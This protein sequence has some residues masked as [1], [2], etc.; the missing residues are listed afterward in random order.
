MDRMCGASI[1]RDKLS[2]SRCWC[3]GL[4]CGRGGAKMTRQIRQHFHISGHATS[5]DDLEA[6]M[7]QADLFDG[8]ARRELW[9]IRLDMR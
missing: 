9:R 6:L 7:A 2:Q 1:E 8:L 5:R 4:F 3:R